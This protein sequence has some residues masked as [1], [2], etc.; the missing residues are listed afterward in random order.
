MGGFTMADGDKLVRYITE[1][2]VTFLETPRGTRIASRKSRKNNKERW[3]Y[4]WFG[5]VPF[6]LGFWIRSVRKKRRKV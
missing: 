1:Q 5:L 4:R 3:A 6:A 2:V